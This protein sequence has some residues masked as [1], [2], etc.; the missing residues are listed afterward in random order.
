VTIWTVEL[1]AAAQADFRDILRWTTLQFGK[2]QARVYEAAL[3]DAIDALI[4]GPDAKGVRKRGDL[5]P[6]L[7][8]LHV[9]RN[10]HKGRHVILFRVDEQKTGTIEVLRILHDSMDLQR[11]LSLQ[12]EPRDFD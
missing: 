3:S 2:A 12:E 6:G 1:A 11:H 7:F 4:V 10:K 5:H 8:M 9:T